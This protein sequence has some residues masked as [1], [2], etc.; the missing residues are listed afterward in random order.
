MPVAAGDVVAVVALAA[1]IGRV[2]AVVAEVAVRFSV[3]PV[4]QS[5][6]PGTG[7]VRDLT[8]VLPHG[9]VLVAVRE[10]GGG[11]V[12]IDVVAGREDVPWM[13][14]MSSP[15]AVS[16]GDVARGDIAG[17]DEDRVSARQWC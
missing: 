6:L 4:P 5:W 2:G 12:G 16:V 13:P 1:G 14:A 7:R 11:A 8:A 3:S 10:L 15:V 17:T 9:V